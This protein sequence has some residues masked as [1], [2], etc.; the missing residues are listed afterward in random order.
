MSLNA[1]LAGVRIVEF[2]GLG[3]GPLAGWMLAGMGA[4]VTMISQ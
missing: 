3:P 1:P 2:E 4:Q